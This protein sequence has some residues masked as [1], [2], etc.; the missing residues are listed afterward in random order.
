MS[1]DVARAPGGAL[2]VEKEI[3]VLG[4]PDSAFR[5]FTEGIAGWWPLATHSVGQNETVTV[6]F[7]GREGGQVFERLSDET[8]AVW[9]RVK[10]WEP[11]HRFTM[12]WHP[13]HPEERATE[14]D[15]RFEL[16]PEGVRIRLRHSGWEVLGEAAEE[17]CRRYTTGWDP[18][19]AR[20]AL[21]EGETG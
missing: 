3:T 2:V 13:G 9:G 15:V 12:S 17:A 19:L 4:S 7:E 21:T 6:V 11:P 14:L 16:V 5:R 1:R 10:L 8:T 18:V 20:F